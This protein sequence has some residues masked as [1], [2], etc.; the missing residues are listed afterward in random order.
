MEKFVKTKLAI[1]GKSDYEEIKSIREKYAHFGMK[2]AYSVAKRIFKEEFEEY[3]K[4]QEET[5][6]KNEKNAE[7]AAA[8]E[9]IKAQAPEEG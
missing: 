4:E 1:N 7:R 6:E 2:I 5:A 3:K 9:D 8:E